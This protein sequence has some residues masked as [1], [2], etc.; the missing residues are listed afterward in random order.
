MAISAV[1]VVF[2]LARYVWNDDKSNLAVFYNPTDE[3]SLL[4]MKDIANPLA[5]FNPQLEI[6]MIAN[7]EKKE[8]PIEILLCSSGKKT[9]KYNGNPLSLK[10]LML[11][12]NLVVD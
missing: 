10:Q 12:V 1:F 3:I 6:T 9:A 7:E 4:F 11:F 8:N 2:V 5:H